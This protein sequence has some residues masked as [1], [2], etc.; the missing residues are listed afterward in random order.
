MKTV[1]ILD[2]IQFAGPSGHSQE[3]L[4][5]NT[6]IAVMIVY[7]HLKSKDETHS[8]TEGAQIMRNQARLSLDM[9]HNG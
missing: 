9:P 4:L 3:Y 5:R 6:I 2:S 8:F 1:P 7:Q